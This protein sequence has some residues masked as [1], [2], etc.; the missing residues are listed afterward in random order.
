MFFTKFGRVKS[1][2]I[3]TLVSVIFTLILSLSISYIMINNGWEVNLQASILMSII[4]PALIAFPLSL[5]TIGLHISLDKSKSDMENLYK[6]S[7]KTNQYLEESKHELKQLFNNASVGLAYIDKNRVLIKANQKV[8]DIFGYNTPDNMIGISMRNL[9]LSKDRF[10]EFGKKNFESLK[11]G[12]KINI[13]YQLKKKDG[14]KIWCEVSGKVL[15]EN[16]PSDFSRGVLWTI[17]NIDKRKQ[18]EE[19][20]NKTHARLEFALEGSV[21]GLWE[22]NITT[23][24][25]YLSPKW[26]RILGYEDN[27][28]KNEFSSWENLVDPKDKNKT[29]QLIEKYLEDKIDSFETKFKMKHKD[30]HYIPILSRAKKQIDNN[31]EIR[32]IGTHFDLTE[33][34]KHEK[35]Q[36]KQQEII[37]QQSKMTAMSEFVSNIAHHWRQPLSVISTSAT[38]LEVQKEF[39]NLNDELIETTVKTI[40]THSQYLSKT[41]DDFGNFINEKKEEKLFDINESIETFLNLVD[42]S[43]QNNS[44]KIISSLEDDLKIFACPTKLIYCFVNLFNNAEEVLQDKETKL[45]FINSYKDLSNLIIEF[46]DNGGGIDNEHILR[47]FEP[48]FTT[49]HKS[50]GTGMGLSIT[51][52]LIVNG[53]NG[54]ITVTNE[55]YE[56]N[57]KQEKG[58]QFTIT[59]PLK[60]Q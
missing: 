22:W 24:E 52:D 49:K 20:K 7:E 31:Q 50:F 14:S 3:I 39:G 9:H 1:S 13:E 11:Y 56:Y 47:I 2:I 58:A 4:I 45:L 33:I 19:Y 6:E 54:L 34:V 48:Y 32:L 5:Y 26:K 53:L 10:E 35:Q 59:I 57:S 38:N 37:F 21:D 40:N 51:Y 18:L 28:I 55:E 17:T 43:I 23:N 8:A 30:G 12:E 25:V 44:I 41:I 60:V 29:L 42:S 46:K 36:K 16:I 15:D 27:E